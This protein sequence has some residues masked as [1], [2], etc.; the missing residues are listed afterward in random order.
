MRGV[1]DRF[2]FMQGHFLPG[3]LRCEF[4]RRP[5]IVSLKSGSLHPR[6]TFG[7]HTTELTTLRDSHAPRPEYQFASAVEMV[8]KI[9]EPSPLIQPPIL[10]VRPSQK[11]LPPNPLGL[12]T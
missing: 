7:Y 4:S 3:G 11:K 2:S 5:K 6:L 8:I 12:N 9:Q 1:G 10:S